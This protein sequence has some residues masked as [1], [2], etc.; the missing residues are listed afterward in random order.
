MLTYNINQTYYSENDSSFTVLWER[1]L[2][3]FSIPQ[4]RI[5]YKRPQSVSDD[6]DW[7]IQDTSFAS[8]LKVLSARNNVLIFYQLPVVKSLFSN[9]VM[10]TVRWA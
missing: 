4:G 7:V 1:T 3:L 6:F 2:P 8:H 9:Y 10:L 5:G